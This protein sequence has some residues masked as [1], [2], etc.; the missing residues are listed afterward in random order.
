MDLFHAAAPIATKRRVH[1]H[2]FMR[3]VHQRI[4]ARRQADQAGDPVPPVATA[5]ASEAT[6]LCF[7]EFHVGDITDA[8]MLGRLFEALF[9]AGVVMVATSNTAPDDLYAGGLNRHRFLPVIDLLKARCETI[10]LT[11]GQD[12]RL[13][14]LRRHPVYCTPRGAESE[15]ALAAAFAELTRGESGQAEGVESAGRTIPVPRAAAGVAWFTFSDLC[16][17]PLGSGDY[18]EIAS[19]YHT[20]LLSGIPKM[21]A[22]QRDGARRFIHLIDALYDHGVNLVASAAAPPAELYT[23]A[24]DSGE[25]ERTAS[26][27]VEMQ[28]D[29]YISGPHRP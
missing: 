26:R 5:L 21:G 22:D 15:Q 1:F 19:R 10:E 23:G 25:F 4:H 11:G 17:A 12:H 8:M 16:E 29:S 27:L 3:D 7:D 2:A 20:I 9:Q 13:A 18:L 28:S 24:R 6:L 14:G